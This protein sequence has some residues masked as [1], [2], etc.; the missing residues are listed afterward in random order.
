MEKGSITMSRKQL[1]RFDILSKANAGFITVRE[2]SE[3]LGL[4][5]RQVK[6]LKKKVRDGGAD[7]V[8]H[9]NAGKPPSNRIPDETKAELLRLWRRPEHAGCNFLHFAEIMGREHGIDISYASLYAI[10]RGEGISPPKTKRRSKPHRRRKR[11]AQAGLLLQMD[12]TP[13]AWF[14]G[15]GRRYALHGAIDD[16]TGQATGLFMTEN[17][18]L[19]GYFETLRRTV[20]NFGVPVSAYADR[21][22]IFQSPNAKRHEIDASVP[23]NDT[24]FG[25]CLKELGVTLITARSPQAKGRVERLW[26]TLQGRLPVE[27][28][29]RGIKTA[30]EANAFL[31]TYVY[32]F[33]AN[34]AVE[35]ENAQSAFRR[36]GGG[37]DMDRILCVKETRVIDAGGVFSYGGKSFRVIDKDAPLPAKTRISVLIGPRIGVMAAYRGKVFECLPFVPPRRKK[38]APPKKPRRAAPPT[39]DHAWR[40]GRPGYIA[41]FSDRKYESEEAY[42][43]T[44]RLVER[45]LLGRGR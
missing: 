30:D 3:A 11:R 6:R 7:G 14:R 21:H 41:T 20:G 33:N 16:A 19:H 15:G 23:M 5:E 18:C 43:E 2:A 4:S 12:A 22:A 9:G 24:Q 17:E 45:A 38:P 25:R 32:E 27:F 37:E 39:P 40:T 10:M 26:G 31:E 44:V 28:A 8:V 13:F 36:L 35:P 42:R 1:T 34:F 29:I